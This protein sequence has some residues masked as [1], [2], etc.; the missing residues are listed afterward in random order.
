MC[1][2]KFMI[3]GLF[4]RHG[5]RQKEKLIPKGIRSERF[6]LEILKFNAVLTQWLVQAVLWPAHGC[7]VQAVLWPA[8]GCFVQAVLWPAHGCFV[9][10]VLWPA[11]GCFVQAVLWPAHGCASG[12]LASSWMLVVARSK[13]GG[14]EKMRFLTRLA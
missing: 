8:H 12:A 3:V 13:T 9:Q 14:A 1:Q 5:F 10:A 11:H 2:R 6:Y 4:V 7:F